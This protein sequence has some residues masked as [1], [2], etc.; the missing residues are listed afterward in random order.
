MVFP[1]SELENRRRR[2][3]SE[4]SNLSP[5]ASPAA[6]MA[7]PTA[8][9]YNQ[10]IVTRRAP[11]MADCQFCKD[12]SAA[13]DLLPGEETTCFWCGRRITGRDKTAP[14]PDKVSKSAP[15]PT[16]GF[17]KPK[18]T[19]LP[20]HPPIE[21]G[22]DDDDIPDEELVDEF[23]D[24][25]D[26]VAPPAMGPGTAR[27]LV[28]PKFTGPARLRPSEPEDDDPL[29]EDTSLLGRLRK[30]DT[31]TASAFF[32]G[33]VALLFASVPGMSLLTKP[34]SAVGLV[35]AVFGSLLPARSRR[36]DVRFPS[37]V[38]GLCILVFLF[39]GSWPR[40]STPPPPPLVSV[41][42]DK[43]TSAAQVLDEGAWVDAA[44][45]SILLQA[46]CEPAS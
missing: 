30:L 6:A 5:S 13:K 46:A 3:A 26:E 21:D 29:E 27:Q 31:P 10:P 16:K 45:G 34:L 33:T 36:A 2:K 22:F 38:T 32:C 43:S 39:A 11:T 1:L 14:A 18:K 28:P 24:E 15:V 37:F 17:D 12:N 20:E 8:R 40:G 44:S 7:V 19:P 25:E 9:K 42:R 35:V 4:S 23:D 41:P